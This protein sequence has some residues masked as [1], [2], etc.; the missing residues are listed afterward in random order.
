MPSHHS[1][2][3]AHPV[4]MDL[5]QVMLLART[6]RRKCRLKGLHRELQMLDQPRTRQVILLPPSQ[7]KIRLNGTCWQ[8]YGWS[9]TNSVRQ[10]Q[11]ESQEVRLS[12]QLGRS[13]RLNKKQRETARIGCMTANSG[14][15]GQPNAPE[16]Y[17]DCGREAFES[18]AIPRHRR[19]SGV[20]CLGKGLVTVVHPSATRGIS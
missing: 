20:R 5:D 8:V 1:K 15:G 14:N 10:P 18:P 9:Q 4:I 17:P 7:A 2:V 13:N 6:G 19:D 12:G 3:I 11:Q 16:R